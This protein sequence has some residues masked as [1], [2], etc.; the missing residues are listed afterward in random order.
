MSSVFST[1]GTGNGLA[2]LSSDVSLTQIVNFRVVA[3]QTLN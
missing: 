1:T 2:E 3:L